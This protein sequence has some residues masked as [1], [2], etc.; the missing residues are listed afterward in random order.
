MTIANFSRP[1]GNGSLRIDA[2]Y[3]VNDGNIGFSEARINIRAHHL[4]AAIGYRRDKK[5]SSLHV[6]IS[7]DGMFRH[8]N[9]TVPK[10]EYALGERHPYVPLQT[11]T[12]RMQLEPFATYKYR[13]SDMISFAYAV[14]TNIPVDDGPT[15]LSHQSNIRFDPDG[16]H[17][18]RFSR[19]VQHQSV[20]PRGGS[21]PV[22]YRSVQVSLDHTFERKQIRNTNAL[23]RKKIE[24]GARTD[25]VYGL[26]SSVRYAFKPASFVELSYTGLEVQ[27]TDGDLP[28]DSPF[29]LDYFVRING[30]WTFAHF[31]TMGLRG[32]FRQGSRYEPLRY[33]LYDH[34]LEV[35]RPVYAGPDDRRRLPPYNTVDLN[36]SRLVPM[37]PKT[38]VVVFG[39]V[40]NLFNFGNVR[41]YNYNQDYTERV[42]EH[43]SRRTVYFG[44]QLHFR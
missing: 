23:F 16:P 18:I 35:F 14:R 21:Q 8:F 28:V 22:L 33:A 31:W 29:D 32:L 6:G 27:S 36:L 20:L 19:G 42:E 9:G 4:Y 1:M 34:S 44:V 40:A 37:G 3:T 11:R 43:F 24:Y 25:I 15:Y 38:A 13:P 5:R 2:G 10:Y 30:Q 12:R 7:Y 39:S 41:G 17:D 26:E